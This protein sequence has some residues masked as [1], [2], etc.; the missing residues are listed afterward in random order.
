MVRILKSVAIF[1]A[2]G[3]VLGA[4]VAIHHAEV[5]SMAKARLP[6]AE[7]F[8]RRAVADDKIIYKDTC[9]TKGKRLHAFDVTITT[10]FASVALA[11]FEGKKKAMPIPLAQWPIEPPENQ[12]VIV[13]A[14]PAALSRQACLQCLPRT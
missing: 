3:G 8:G 5:T 9:R 1:G 7:E 6:E 4:A 11:V 14:D 2:F 10:P 12:S 13:S